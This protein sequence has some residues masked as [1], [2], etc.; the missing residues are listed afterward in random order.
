MRRLLVCPS[1]RRRY[2][3]TPVAVGGRVRCRCGTT[4]DVREEEVH[5]AA[6]V[7]CQSCGATREEGAA[8]CPFCGSD[9]TLH[10]QDLDTMC[11][12]CFARVSGRARFCHHCAAPIFADEAAGD[13]TE[14]TCPTCESAP[15]RSRALQGDG[16][17][18][19]ECNRC[20]GLWLG[21]EAFARLR[22][23]TLAAADPNP[24]A[25]AI[26]ADAR[27]RRTGG[28]A[29]GPQYRRCPICSVR[30]NRVNYGKQS[31]I[32]LDRCPRDGLWFD[33][34]ELDAVLRWMR[35]GGERLSAEREARE[36]REKAALA[37]FRVE[38]KA[39]EDTMR[40]FQ[41]G[42]DSSDFLGSLARWLGQRMR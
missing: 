14:R 24:D 31:G 41:H 7:R 40:D 6:V 33:G 20:G 23:A 30:M 5:D 42:D 17:S 11:P 25:G 9:F 4:L 34:D 27:E 22:E 29:R 19:L 16:L 2:D 39:P 8:S 32:L 28:N 13:L 3:A 36:V 18:A 10:E 15:L 38:P 21:A 26:R 35:L 37:R 1:C 12:G